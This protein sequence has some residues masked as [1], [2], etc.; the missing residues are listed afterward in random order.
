MWR[1]ILLWKENI[2]ESR[3]RVRQRPVRSGGS[4]RTDRMMWVVRPD[5][6][7][8]GRTKMG[9]AG[10]RWGRTLTDLPIGGQ[11][12]ERTT[13][14]VEEGRTF[15]EE[16]AIIEPGEPVD[17]DALSG[18]LVQITL[19]EGMTPKVSHTIQLVA[20]MMAQLRSITTGDAVFESM[21]TKVATLVGK[22]TENMEAAVSNMMEVLK[23]AAQGLA[24]NTVKLTEM[25]ASYKDVLVNAAPRRPP[26]PLGNVTPS[27]ASALAPR[28]QAREGVRERQVLIDVD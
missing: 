8:D 19:M 14:S 22:A 18:A 7:G 27:H 2:R 25:T 1:N 23:E 4:G 13:L 15:L 9:T 5:K 28:L 24:D 12:S 17:V 20:L 6:D 26:R 11:G 21:E 3:K 16:E 10:Q